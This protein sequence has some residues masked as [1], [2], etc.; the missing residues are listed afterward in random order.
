MIDIRAIG[1]EGWKNR[2]LINYKF[3]A[4]RGNERKTFGFT[5]ADLPLMNPFDLF[6]IFWLLNRKKEVEK[7]KHYLR[8]IKLMI[9]CYI[10]EIGKEDFEV[11]QKFDRTV[12]APNDTTDNIDDLRDGTILTDSWSIVYKIHKD[13]RLQSRIFY[14]NEK[15]RYSS[16]NLNTI[17]AK[18]EMNTRNKT[19]NK[20]H[21]SD[22]IKWWI[23]VRMFLVNEIENIFD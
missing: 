14:M 11:A 2:T 12:E 1:S 16:F 8:H 4:T 18:M 7:Y 23:M 19:A 10:S 17:L 13:G 3:E 5:C 21:I 9:K 20:K 22:N 15:H 6:N